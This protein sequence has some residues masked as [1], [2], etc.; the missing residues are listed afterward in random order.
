MKTTTAGVVCLLVALTLPAPATSQEGHPMAGTWIGT[1][2]PS[3]TV[4]HRV[5]IEMTWTG[6][7][8]AGRINPGPKAIAFR[9]GTV[10][11]ADWILHIEADTQDAQGRPVTYVIDGTLDNLGSYNRGISGTWNVG[12]TKGTFQIFRQ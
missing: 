6:K 8:L 4:R 7:T 2:G 10:E 11:P 5:V 1:W 12:A 9:V 3:Q